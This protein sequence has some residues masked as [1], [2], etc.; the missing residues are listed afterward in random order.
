MGDQTLWGIHAGRT[1]DALFRK[2]CVIGL[3]WTRIP[4]LSKVAASRDDLPTT[5]SPALVAAS[6][7]SP[8]GGACRLPD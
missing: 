7:Y 6:S 8:K 3:G 2:K 5:T 4:D 1:S